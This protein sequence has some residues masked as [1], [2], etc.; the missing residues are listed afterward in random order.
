MYI[1]GLYLN[2]YRIY[3]QNHETTKIGDENSGYPIYVN[4]HNWF[5]T[6]SVIRIVVQ[7]KLMQ[8]QKGQGPTHRGKNSHG[9]IYL[10]NSK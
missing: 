4:S 6:K 2:P 8:Q 1:I 9:G 5:K 10:S 7:I 3:G